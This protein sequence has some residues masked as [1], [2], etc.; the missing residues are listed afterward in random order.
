[1]TNDLTAAVKAWARA[2]R[3][4]DAPALGQILAEDFAAIG[5]RGFQVDREQWLA[6]FRSGSYLNSRLDWD[7]LQV[8]DYG[9]T[10]IV[11]GVQTSEGAFQGQ[12]VG[13]RYR[14]TQ[15]YI[16]QGGGWKL[17]AMQLSEMAEPPAGGPPR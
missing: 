9:Q 16:E 7:E 17:A 14:G 6:R 8:R 12:H 4:N 2:E 13:G 1:M 15:V 11:R 3:E 10:A 5:P